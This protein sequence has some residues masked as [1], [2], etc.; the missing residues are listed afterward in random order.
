[1]GDRMQAYLGLLPKSSNSMWVEFWVRP[2]DLFR[3]CPDNDITDNSCDL[4]L[5]EN[6]EPWYREWFNQTRAHQYGGDAYNG[7]RGYPWTQLGYTYDWWSTADDRIGGS[8]FVIKANANI[9]VIDKQ[10]TKQYCK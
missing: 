3:P 6:V 2:Q 9:V 8:E 1:M 10:P 7:Y 4:C 5:P